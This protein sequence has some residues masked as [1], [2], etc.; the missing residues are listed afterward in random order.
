MGGQQGRVNGETA[1]V[2]VLLNPSRGPQG[3]PMESLRMLKCL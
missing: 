2:S 3:R 1:S